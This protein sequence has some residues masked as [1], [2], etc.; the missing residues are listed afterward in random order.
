MRIKIKEGNPN[1]AWNHLITNQDNLNYS[2]YSMKIQEL[3]QNCDLKKIGRIE[4]TVFI[5][6]NILVP[7]SLLKQY[8]VLSVMKMF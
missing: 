7:I 4:S 5:L 1:G 2:I 6:K 3:E 8:N